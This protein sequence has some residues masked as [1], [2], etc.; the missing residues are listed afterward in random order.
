MFHNTSAVQL[1]LTWDD[2]QIMCIPCSH[3][4]PV[5]VDLRKHGQGTGLHTKRKPTHARCS[6]SCSDLGKGLV[7]ADHGALGD[8]HAN[9]ARSSSCGAGVISN[10][11]LGST[12][13]FS[14]SSPKS[15]PVLIPHFCSGAFSPV[16]AWPGWKGTEDI[17]RKLLAFDLQQGRLWAQQWLHDPG[18]MQGT[19]QRRAGVKI[20]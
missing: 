5:P 12:Q 15:A 1:C 11:V 10:R 4:R 16:Q 13:G 20:A 2:M 18:V 6:T 8:Q 19:H 3:I 14:L 17:H 7:S 9:A